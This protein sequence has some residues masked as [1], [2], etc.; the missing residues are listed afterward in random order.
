LNGVVVWKTVKAKPG[1]E[2]GIRAP[3]VEK[4][5]GGFGV[6]KKAVPEII[7]EVG[8]SGRE[9]RDEVVFGRP[10]CPLCR[11]GSVNLWGHKLRRQP[12][13]E[14]ILYAL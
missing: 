3:R 10:Y 14:K 2:G 12:W 11:V 9:Q 5:K 6:G 13:Q 8:V 1:T 4:V 7:R